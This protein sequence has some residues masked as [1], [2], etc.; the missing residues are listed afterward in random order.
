MKN[1]AE[2]FLV[3]IVG[4]AVV[5]ALW[6]FNK[7]AATYD[8]YLVGN[9]IALFWVPFMTIFLLLREDAA[10]FGFRNTDS[11]GVWWI[12]AAMYAALLIGMLFACRW[13]VFQDYYPIFRHFPEFASAFRAYPAANPFTLEPVLMAYA[14][15]SYGMYLFCWEFFFRGFLL[16]GLQRSIGWWAVIAQAVAFGLL[17]IGKPMPEV[18]CS[19]AAGLILGWL[20]LK[21]KSFLPCFVLHWAASMTFDLLVVW[22]RV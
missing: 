1:R 21:S 16:F 3:T 11:R 17:H 14:L 12:V 18:I 15:A 10:N 7:S 5:I 4:V 2:T 22:G 19:F 6:H 9:L 8:R 20:A 13:T